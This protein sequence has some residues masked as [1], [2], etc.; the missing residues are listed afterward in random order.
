MDAGANASVAGANAKAM[1]RIVT[2]TEPISPDRSMELLCCADCPCVRKRKAHD[3]CVRPSDYSF[4]Y[5]KRKMNLKLFL[6][7]LSASEM[8]RRG[9]FSKTL[10]QPVEIP[11]FHSLLPTNRGQVCGE[12]TVLSGRT[13]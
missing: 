12:C 2:C 10:G 8:L 4:L 1:A 7:P 5:V 9:K 11:A 6:A 3:T 13:D